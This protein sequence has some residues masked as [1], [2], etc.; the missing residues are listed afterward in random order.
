M[1]LTEQDRRQVLRT[2]A[3]TWAGIVVTAVLMLAAMFWFPGEGR[4]GPRGYSFGKHFLSAM[5]KTRTSVSDN[6]ISCLIFNGTLI[7]VGTILV[8]FWKTRATFLTRPVAKKTVRN[9]GLTMGLAMAG[10]G[11]TP[12]D[13]FP[14]T[15][16]LMTHS[17]ILFGVICFGL[18]LWGS[19]QEFES[20]KSKLGWLTIVV[21]QPMGFSWCWL[22]RASS[23][24]AP[25]CRSCKN[26]LCACWRYGRGGRVFSLGESAE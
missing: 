9:C 20:V 3:L 21:V 17:V 5:G 13:I 16:N 15:H 1:T 8:M 26:Y 11:L 23:P 12:Y 4:G 7:M 25:R 6:T 19:P 24:A 18:C 2:R 22:R 10:I 14:H